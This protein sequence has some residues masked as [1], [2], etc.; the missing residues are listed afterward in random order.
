MARVESQVPTF[1]TFLTRVASRVISHV[2]TPSWLFL[3]QR[4]DFS[5]LNFSLRMNFSTE[6]WKFEFAKIEKYLSVDIY[7]YG[8]YKIEF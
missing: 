1:G 6:S 5:R 2:K 7:L 8:K 4:D 3:R